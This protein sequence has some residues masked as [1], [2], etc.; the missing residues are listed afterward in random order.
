MQLTVV[1]GADCNNVAMT[2][3]SHMSLALLNHCPLVIISCSITARVFFPQTNN[4]HEY[5]G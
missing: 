2:G 1:V 5:Q 4:D 3:V